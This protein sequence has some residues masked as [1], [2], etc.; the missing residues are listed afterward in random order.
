MIRDAITFGFMARVKIRKD[1]CRACEMARENPGASSFLGR[2]AGIAGEFLEALSPP[3]AAA[4]RAQVETVKECWRLPGGL[5]TSGIVNRNSTL[6]YHHDG[7]N[8]KGSWNCMIALPQDIEGGELVVPEWGARL[9]FKQPCIV[10]FDG[11][12]FLHGVAPFE[13]MTGRAYRYTIVY[14]ALQNLRL[15]GTPEEEL[16]RIKLVKTAQARK[17]VLKDPK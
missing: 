16:A 2:W 5:F 15:C 8:F 7:G 3:V 10:A 4:Q 11:Q 13:R 17:R 14:Y 12:R 6:T 1:F 9:A